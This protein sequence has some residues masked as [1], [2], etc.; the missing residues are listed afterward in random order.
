MLHP[1]TARIAKEL[2]DYTPFTEEEGSE[3]FEAT[4]TYV[5]GETKR[6][7]K[8]G[9]VRRNPDGLLVMYYYPSEDHPEHCPDENGMSYAYQSEGWYEVPSNEDIEEWS[10]DSVCFTP[11]ESEVEPDHPDSWLRLLGMI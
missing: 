8:S 2:T 11:D 1:D 9:D 10:L 3:Q 6:P 5:Q 7:A 4:V